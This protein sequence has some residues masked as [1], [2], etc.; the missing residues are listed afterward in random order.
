MAVVEKRVGIRLS[1]SDAYI[2]VAGG[3]R[4]NEPAIDLAMV[5]AI[6]S[7]HRNIVI[8]Q[9]M[10]VFGEVGLSGE[11]RSISQIQ[12]RLLEAKKLGYST[13]MIPKNAEVG[14]EIEGSMKIIRV[15]SIIEAIQYL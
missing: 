7:S 13:C 6:V 4:V 5:L 3:M 12:P 11:V 2:N 9:T 8:E 14:V 1:Q 15:S 10:V